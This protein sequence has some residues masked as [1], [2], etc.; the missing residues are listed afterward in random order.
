M[1]MCVPYV[2]PPTHLQEKYYSHTKQKNKGRAPSETRLDTLHARYA[3][4]SGGVTF[5]P[6]D[7][8]TF[9]TS[10]KRGGKTE[11]QSDLAIYRLKG[12]AMQWTVGAT[13][14][15]WLVPRNPGT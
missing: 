14:S 6:T 13:G 4:L 7:K 2:A 9:P 15:G 1:F 11:L 10:A 5:S 3:F 12:G 8:S